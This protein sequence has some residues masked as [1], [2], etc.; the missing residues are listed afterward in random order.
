MASW[1]M[2]LI[3]VTMKVFF[4]PGKCEGL[5]KCME[6]GKYSKKNTIRGLQFCLVS[7]KLF[8]LTKKTLHIYC[9]WRNDIALHKIYNEMQY[10]INFQ[11]IMLFTFLQ[12]LLFA[13]FVLG[14]YHSNVCSYQR[15][16]KEKH[17][18]LISV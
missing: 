3:Y 13:L 14:R 10:K 2:H 17:C 11:I 9:I 8:R 18:L 1:Y 7:S 15:H 16:S 12:C 5:N 6:V 4:G